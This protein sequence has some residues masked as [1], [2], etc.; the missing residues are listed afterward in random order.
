MVD[1]RKQSKIFSDISRK[2]NG[3]RLRKAARNKKPCTFA[4]LLL[5]VVFK[6]CTKDVNTYL[7]NAT[8]SII[9]HENTAKLNWKGDSTCLGKTGAWINE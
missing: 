8:K 4:N 3:T 5:K 6:T 7:D 1:R 2:N 9:V